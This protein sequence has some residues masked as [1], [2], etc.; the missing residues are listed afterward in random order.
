MSNT[1]NV[2]ISGASGD[3]GSAVARQLAAEGYHLLLHYFRNEAR[4][5]ALKQTLEDQGA[6]V[7]LCQADLRSSAGAQKLLEAK[8]EVFGQSLSGLVNV[9]GTS[10]NGLIQDTTDE[11]WREVMAS[12]LDA[13]F[14]SCRAFAGDLIGQKSGSIINISSMW[15]LA[16]AAMES[17][18]SAA[19]AGVIGLTQALARE[20]GP[21][22]I[23]AN[24]IAPG[25]IEGRMNNHYGQA[26]LD[27]LAEET[28]LGRL[29]QPEEIAGIVSF[30]LSPQSSY[31]TG[32]VLLADGGFLNR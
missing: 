32:Q 13:V 30:L 14:Y 18:Y 12:N 27:S 17:A 21:S 9:T 4:A 1:K 20:L 7:T 3:I 15:G 8:R 11:V 26:A 29:G 24:V 31:V 5:E 10:Y 23:R 6:R 25:V 28:S 16:G 2:V 19:K 22:G